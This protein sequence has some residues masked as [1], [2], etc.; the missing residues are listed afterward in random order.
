MKCPK[1]SYL[2]ST[3]DN[4]RDS[5]LEHKYRRRTCKN[6]RHTYT[7]YEIELGRLL[8]LFEGKFDNTTFTKMEEILMKEFPTMDVKGTLNF[9][10]S[11]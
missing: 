3:V 6:C 4:V 8:T 2:K 7:S 9:K 11:T 1:C 10:Q 5:K